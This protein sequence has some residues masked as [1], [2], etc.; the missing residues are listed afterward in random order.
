MDMKENLRI[1]NVVKYPKLEPVRIEV[2]VEPKPTI[3]SSFDSLRKSMLR[4]DPSVRRRWTQSM[5]GQ[6][7]AGMRK[8]VGDFVNLFWPQFARWS[9][10]LW[11]PKGFPTMI[12]EV[13]KEDAVFTISKETRQFIPR[14]YRLA[15]KLVSFFRTLGVFS[16]DFI[17]VKDMKMISRMGGAYTKLAK[18]ERSGIIEYLE[19]ASRT[20]EHYFRVYESSDCRGLDN[21][22]TT[23]ASYLPP[24]MIGQLIGLGKDGRDWNAIETKCIVA[25]DPYCEWE[26]I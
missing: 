7:E 24:H 12:Y 9:S 21:V 17:K 20:D 2:P 26:I 14:R 23:I 15:I 16:K 1:I 5:M 11:D 10:M 4:L 18:T 3:K 25:G 19:D 8:E 6:N 13:N 22:G